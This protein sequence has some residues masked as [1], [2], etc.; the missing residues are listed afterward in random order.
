MIYD[1]GL[2]FAFFIL[3]I[4]I[5]YFIVVF[6]ILWTPT[7]KKLFSCAESM[8]TFK[9]SLGASECISHKGDQNAF[10][11]EVLRTNYAARH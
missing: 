3:Y 1:L 8:Y 9:V 11:L 7:L 6:Y 4:Y 10:C 5:E 2:Q